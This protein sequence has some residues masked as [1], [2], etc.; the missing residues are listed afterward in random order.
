MEGLG[1]TDGGDRIFWCPRCGTIR[2]RELISGTVAVP[3]AY[4]ELDD[5]PKLVERSRQIAVS[6]SAAI[7]YFPTLRE[8]DLHTL[9]HTSGFY[10]SCMTPEQRNALS[11]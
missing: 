8:Y 2:T 7:S 5:T 9:S 6:I 10:E 1:R 3:V 11:R 4:R